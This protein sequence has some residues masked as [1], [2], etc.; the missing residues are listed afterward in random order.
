MANKEIPVEEQPEKH[1]GGR[2]L[3]FGTI[4]ELEQAIKS[5][6]NEC[7]PHIAKRIVETGRTAKDEAIWELREVMTEQKPYTMSGLARH[8]EI[9]RR[10]L[11]NYAKMEQFFP[12][13]QAARERV[14][15]FAEEQLYGK[16]AGGAQFV[17]KNNF[18]WKDRSEVD[19]TTKDQ[20]LAMVEFI[21][22]G[23]TTNSQDPVS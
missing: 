6:F 1:P 22:G 8:M 9:D 2:P 23:S 17:L 7:D 13:V 3:A 19:L 4:D 16:S 12:T 20:P 15:E 10:T 21:G 11:V 5:Y 14:H 18:D